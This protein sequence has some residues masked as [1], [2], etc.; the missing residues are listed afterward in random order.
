MESKKDIGNYFKENLEQLDYSPSPKI[1]EGIEVELKKK[2]KRRFVFW[3]FF[4]VI[5]IL[6]L[7]TFTYVNHSNSINA[8][9]NG[10]VT[11]DADSRNANSNNRN[12]NLNNINSNSSDSNNM[13]PNK[14]DS[15]N[16]NKENKVLNNKK[17]NEIKRRSELIDYENNTS[18]KSNLD[19]NPGIN[20]KPKK[21]NT[22]NKFTKLESTISI[23][24]AN[25]KSGEKLLKKSKTANNKK[26][27][28]SDGGNSLFAGKKSA[29]Y[30]KKANKQKP[31]NGLKDNGKN[32]NPDALKISESNTISASEK[33]KFNIDDLKN[34]ETNITSASDKNK[35]LSLE[36]LKKA[37]QKKRDSLIAARKIEK[38]KKDLAQK[39][40]EEEEKDSTTTELADSGH[41]II[42]A[43]YFGYNYNGNLGNGNFL[44]DSKT[45]KKDSQFQ[46]SYG[47]LVRWMGSDKIGFQTGIG[48]INSTYSATFEK[49]NNNFINL[50]NVSLSIPL[51]DI[52][53]LFP[54]GTTTTIV[55][56]TN[57]LSFIEVPLEGYY[58]FTDKKFGFATALGISFMISQKKDLFL[59]SDNV[60][61]LKVG[62]LKN[63]SPF[64]VTGNI[65]LNLFYKISSK[66]QFDLYPEFQYHLMEFKEVSN[67][68][69]YYFSIKTGLSYKL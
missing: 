35:K 38:E 49:T 32:N 62:E 6:G 52:N 43:P 19:L 66:L 7:S 53:Q 16:I 8:S 39:P 25:K 22:K 40:K 31:L 48:I 56:A 33:E 61:R 12:N 15:N 45:S 54:S 21:A 36:D 63:I 44:N 23:G 67:Y 47:V 10:V 41:E 30:S 11:R 3:M 28:E 14:S 42:I 29:Q 5:A 24:V 65:K 57:K 46:S 50:Q 34:P 59:E 51:S 4:A 2:K 13:N 9:S 69:S 68:H 18:G 64:S 26:G 27:I 60:K 1:W 58:I 17:E 55:T 20:S 37:N